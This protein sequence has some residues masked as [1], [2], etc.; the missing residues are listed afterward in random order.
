MQPSII[1]KKNSK[2]KNPQFKYFAA[3]VLVSLTFQIYK[4]SIFSLQLYKIIKNSTRG[5][6][7]WKQ[8]A[9]VSGF[10]LNTYS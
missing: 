7:E 1:R 10:P 3:L 9:Q 4:N 5:F 6:S 2:P 8:K